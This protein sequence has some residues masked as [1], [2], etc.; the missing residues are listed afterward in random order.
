VNLLL[1][2]WE[3]V[4]TRSDERGKAE[5]L[6]TRFSLRGF[7]RRILE[8]DAEVYSRNTSALERVEN[9]K[10]RLLFDSRK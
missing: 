5:I 8:S 10:K 3:L 7:G 2:K 9:V 6:R 1:R 4:E